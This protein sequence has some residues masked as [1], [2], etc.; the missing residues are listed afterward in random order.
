MS[1][2]FALEPVSACWNEVMVLAEQHWAGTKSY[3]RHEPFCPSFERYNAYDQ[4][5]VFRLFTARD[6][7]KLV[8]YFGTY[9]SLSMH[10][11]LPMTVEDTM[12]LRHDYRGGRNA[13][14]FLLFIEQ[15]CR[16]WKIHENL[17]SCEIDNETGIKEL[18]THLD[19]KPVIVQYSKHLASPPRA[20]S[21]QLIP[22]EDSDVCAVTTPSA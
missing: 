21:A 3:R 7:R 18:L 16:A 12:F 4:A 19:Y 8:G 5:A 15:Q 6:Q 13:L 10:S 9:R 14:R 20:D 2:V 17:F 11:Q 1:L 22:A